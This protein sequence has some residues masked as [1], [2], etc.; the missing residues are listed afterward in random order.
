MKNKCL[1]ICIL[2]LCSCSKSQI[3]YPGFESVVHHP[4]IDDLTGSWRINNLITN[5]ETKE[6]FLYPQNQDPYQNYGNNITLKPDGVFISGYSA[7]CGND[8]FTT[9]LGKYKRIDENYIC[10]FLEKITQTG[11]CIGE[12]E[13]KKDLGKY[14]VYNGTNQKVLLKSTGDL[15]MDRKAAKNIW[16]VNSKSREISQYHGLLQWMDTELPEEESIA[17]CLKENGIDVYEV[18]YSRKNDYSN[19]TIFLIQ[20][21]NE[22]YYVLVKKKF[23]KSQVALFDDSFIREV[24]EQTAQIEKDTSLKVENYKQPYDK[25]VNPLVKNDA[26]VFKKGKEIKK[27]IFNQYF[28]NGVSSS[29]IHYFE[30]NKPFYAESNID[31]KNY[32]S[33]VGSYIVDWDNNEGFSKIISNPGNGGDISSLKLSYERFMKFIQ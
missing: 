6:Y 3:N 4:E 18:I 13:P 15:E 23:N 24:D 28:E 19:E 29:T 10:F 17:F 22:Y 12:N 26:E 9:T 1:I 14:Y 30:N 16:L 27:V 21:A 5:S 25:S 33:V 7:E 20:S 11:D 2:I 8:C 31:F 32:V